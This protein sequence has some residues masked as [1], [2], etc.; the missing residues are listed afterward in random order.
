MQVT[1]KAQVSKGQGDFGHFQSSEQY[2]NG[3]I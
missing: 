3:C 1:G 2:A